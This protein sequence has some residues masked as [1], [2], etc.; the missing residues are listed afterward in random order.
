MKHLTTTPGRLAAALTALVLALGWAGSAALAADPSTVKINRVDPRGDVTAS[1][2]R[3]ALTAQERSLA[4][5][6]GVTYVVDRVAQTVQVNYVVARLG[7]NGDSQT[8]ETT[9]VGDRTTPSRTIITDIDRDTF[10]GAIVLLGMVDGD[11]RYRYCSQARTT[12]DRTTG[13]VTLRAP[14]SCIR[15]APSTALRSATYIENQRLRTLLSD[16]TAKTRT[17]LVT[18]PA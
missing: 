15:S 13:R 12:F 14:L 1:P 17:F 18:P 5:L 10:K 11:P 16:R 4:D 2:P 6:T 8:F 3:A 7:R 9:F